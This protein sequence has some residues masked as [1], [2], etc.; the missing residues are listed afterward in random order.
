MGIYS[1][2]LIYI[3]RLIKQTSY[4]TLIQKHPELLTTH[5]NWITDFNDT[6]GFKILHI[7]NSL[8]IL[9][10]YSGLIETNDVLNKYVKWSE[11]KPIIGEEKA[12]YFL[13][14]LNN[15]I[16]VKQIQ[17]YIH[18]INPLDTLPIQAYC[19]QDGW[20]T[21][22]YDDEKQTTTSVHNYKIKFDC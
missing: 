16:L 3:G 8:L 11:I 6:Q 20:S 7:P 21:L 22:N 4:Q 18:S 14:L 19:F 2:T 15:I 17:T 5:N 1:R 9:S 13:S 12:N 10:P